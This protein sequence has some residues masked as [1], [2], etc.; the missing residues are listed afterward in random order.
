MADPPI[1]GPDAGNNNAA[2][3]PGSNPPMP[4]WVKVFG[5]IAI[6]LVLAVAIG[7]LTGQLGPGGEH[8]PGRHTGSSSSLASL[9]VIHQDPEAG[10]LQ[11]AS[12]GR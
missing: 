9:Y 11:T 8:G 2:P 4:R 3:A 12:G 7:F 10:S 6:I 5:I 1:A